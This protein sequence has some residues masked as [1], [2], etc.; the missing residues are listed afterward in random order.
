LAS[1]KQIKKGRQKK[2]TNRSFYKE[3]QNNCILYDER[4]E[5]LYKNNSQL[6]KI[7]KQKD[8]QIEKEMFSQTIITIQ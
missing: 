5:I 1:I 8:K 6:R 4:L 7:L 2:I 3:Q